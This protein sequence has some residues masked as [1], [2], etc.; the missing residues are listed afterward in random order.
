MEGMSGM[1]KKPRNT[2]SKGF[3]VAHIAEVGKMDGNRK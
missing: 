2:T 3:L 1:E